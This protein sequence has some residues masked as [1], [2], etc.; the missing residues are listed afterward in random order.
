MSL[1]AGLAITHTVS[2]G[3]ANSADPNVR[4]IILR[5]PFSGNG[6]HAENSG[7]IETQRGYAS[8]GT[9]LAGS[10]KN[11]GLIAATTSVSRNGN[12]S[13]TA[14]TVTLAGSADATRAS[15]LVILPDQTKFADPT[16][17]IEREETIPQG[18]PATRQSSN[19]RKFRSAL[20]TSIR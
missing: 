4:G 7:L 8:L 9:G 17:G 13:L 5:T 14:G 3:A 18:T 15:G 2:T 1:Q 11:S 19:S 12:I 20:F 6:A 16:D 10:V